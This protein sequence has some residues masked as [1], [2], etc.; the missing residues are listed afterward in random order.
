MTVDRG[1]PYLPDFRPLS[2]YDS[3]PLG[4]G[5]GAGAFRGVPSSSGVSGTGALPGVLWIDD[6]SGAGA[7]IR[8]LS[9]GGALP[10]PFVGDSSSS[11]KHLLQS[12][13]LL[14]WKVKLHIYIFFALH[15][16][17]ASLLQFLLQTIVI[18]LFTSVLESLTVD[19]SYTGG[20]MLCEGLVQARNKCTSQT[21]IEPVYLYQIGAPDNNLDN[22]Q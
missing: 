9:T 1:A 2:D 4:A 14:Y 5:S 3:V 19:G 15:K 10:A 13:D 18:N 22:T 21:N 16:T 8:A 12:S 11:V 17:T 20:L 6:M 7:F